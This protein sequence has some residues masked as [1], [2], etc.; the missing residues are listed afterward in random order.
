MVDHL[1][2]LRQPMLRQ[3]MSVEMEQIERLHRFIHRIDDVSQL[4]PV[5]EIG[6]FFI[7]MPIC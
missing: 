1:V 2:L 7:E 3:A 6:L 5:G 4:Q